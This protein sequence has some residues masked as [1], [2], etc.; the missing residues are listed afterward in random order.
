MRRYN[1]TDINRLLKLQDPNVI[2]QTIQM[3]VLVEWNR[4][5]GRG[6]FEGATGVGKSRVGVMAA[7]DEFI[8]NPNAKVYIGTPTETLRDVGWPEEF[9]KWGAGDLIPK[10]KFICH[11]SMQKEVVIGEV[12]LF[13]WDECHHAT[14][15]NASFFD[16]NKVWKILALSATLPAAK[17][18]VNDMEK[19]KILDRLCPC[20]F[21]VPIEDAIALKLVTDFTVK[22]LKFRLNS[23]DL[24][25]PHGDEILTEEEKY[26]RLTKSL[27]LAMFAKHAKHA[28]LPRMQQRMAFI[29]DSTTKRKIAKDVIDAVVKPNKRTL[30]FFG[31][32]EMC[33][34]F[35]W[36]WVYHSKVDKE[37]LNL[38]KEKK[39]HFLGAVKALNEGENIEDVDQIIVVQLNSKDRDI[40]QRIGRAIRWREGVIPTIIILVAMGTVDEQWYKKAFKNFNKKR[41]QEH[42]IKPA[43]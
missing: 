7:I 8:K 15:E 6:A 30:L 29:Y 14:P 20:I 33:N 36:P 39:N 28:K 11:A 13:I 21:R 5:H 24:E 34:D 4:F 38:F 35:C 17:G 3:D 12:D 27:Q 16:N 22:V 42:I 9:R 43:A 37:F 10:I 2:K 40:I 31:T 18:D 25:F 26:Q 23:V 19:R 41:I 32:T 1:Q